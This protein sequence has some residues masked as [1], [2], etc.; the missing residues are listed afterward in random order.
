M[1]IIEVSIAMG[2]TALMCIGLFGI[3]VEIMRFGQYSRVA[4]EAR[5]L[6][7]QRLEEMLAAGRTSLAQPSCTLLNADTNLSS[8]GYSIVRTPRVIWHDSDKSVVDV[9]SN[10]YAE[11]NV[12][13]AFYSP[14]VKHTIT[15]NF[16]MIIQ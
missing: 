2:V 12:A 9:S 5:S 14:T 6:G 10:D 8:L 13:V 11:V 15:N 3:G 16:S 1:T 4:T 7:K